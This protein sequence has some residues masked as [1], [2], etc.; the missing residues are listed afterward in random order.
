MTQLTK[1]CLLC[2]SDFHRPEG[3]RLPIYRAT[4]SGISGRRSSTLE[5]NVLTMIRGKKD[6]PHEHL[7]CVQR[8]ITSQTWGVIYDPPGKV[9][10]AWIS[11]IPEVQGRL[12]RVKRKLF[13]MMRWL[14]RRGWERGLGGKIK[15]TDQGTFKIWHDKSQQIFETSK[16]QRDIIWSGQNYSRKAVLQMPTF[17][18]YKERRAKWKKKKPTSSSGIFSRECKKLYSYPIC[19]KIQ[20]KPWVLGEKDDYKGWVVDYVAG[21]ILSCLVFL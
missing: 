10:L 16:Y 15:A 6:E 20:R 9:H 21:D 4:P 8:A 3:R 12:E 18:Y 11:L 5:V 7:G 13:W 14:G 1:S 2:C 19:C 17:W